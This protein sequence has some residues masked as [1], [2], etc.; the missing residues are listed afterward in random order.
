MI[1]NGTELKNI[2]QVQLLKESFVF[3]LNSVLSRSF[4]ERKTFSFNLINV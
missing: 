1:L 2:Y 4:Q 3:Q